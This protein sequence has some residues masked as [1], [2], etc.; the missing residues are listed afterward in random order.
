MKPCKGRLMS[1]NNPFCGIMLAKIETRVAQNIQSSLVVVTTSS[2]HDARDSSLAI[3]SADDDHDKQP[4]RHDVRDGRRRWLSRRAGK[5]AGDRCS[6]RQ[7]TTR[8]VDVWPRG[9]RRC[10]GGDSD[11]MQRRAVKRRQFAARVVDSERRS[12]TSG[13]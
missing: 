12:A 9:E 8:H 6:R 5:R 4:R 11:E 3:N 1:Q 7:P 2:A 13:A 10:V